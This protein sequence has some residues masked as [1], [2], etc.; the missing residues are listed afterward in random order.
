MRN[1]V[2][3]SI[4]LQTFTVLEPVQKELSDITADLIERLDHDGA[5]NLA[6]E[7]VKYIRSIDVPNMVSIN[8]NSTI[9]DERTNIYDLPIKVGEDVYRNEQKS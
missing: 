1:D 4:K 5:I 3:N 2:L 8:N 9:T 6:K 7:L